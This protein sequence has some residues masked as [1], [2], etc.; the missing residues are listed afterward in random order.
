ME[1]RESLPILK[2]LNNIKLSTAST[3]ELLQITETL[4]KRISITKLRRSVDNAIKNL[5]GVGDPKFGADLQII[6]EDNQKRLKLIWFLVDRM[7]NIEGNIK[8]FKKNKFKCR[9]NPDFLFRS[10][11][12][13][14]ELL[15]TIKEYGD[16][17]YNEQKEMQLYLEEINRKLIG[18]NSNEG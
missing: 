11:E 2:D 6:A 9:E 18:G 1:N 15:D 13:I 3:K 4:F 8:N 16:F 7:N 12:Q 10:I 17:K 14:K 5:S